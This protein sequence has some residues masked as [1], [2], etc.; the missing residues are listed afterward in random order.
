MDTDR[1]ME[2]HVALINCTEGVPPISPRFLLVFRRF[3]GSHYKRADKVGELHFESVHRNRKNTKTCVLKRL[4]DLLLTNS[5][6]T[7]DE[8]LLSAIK[9]EIIWE[10]KGDWVGICPKFRSQD[11]GRQKGVRVQGKKKFGPTG[12]GGQAKNLY[13]RSALM[14][15]GDI[16]K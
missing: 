6:I 16:Y 3:S 7:Q 4:T 15:G 14:W 1:T 11:Y 12:E 10:R 5:F 9:S 8:S 2:S 13:S